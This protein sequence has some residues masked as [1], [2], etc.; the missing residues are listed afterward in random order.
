[1][2][3]PNLESQLL[4]YLSQHDVVLARV[5]VPGLQGR[6]R[7]EPQ[8]PTRV[9]G[10]HPV[11]Q[12]GGLVDEVPTDCPGGSACRDNIRCGSQ[13]CACGTFRQ[14]WLRLWSLNRDSDDGCR[15]A[16]QHEWDL[17]HLRSW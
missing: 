10:V 6:L 17:V 15:S 7:A 5:T 8:V 16:C 14:A 3:G 9:V 1:M 13:G 11:H 2:D 4:K 12:T